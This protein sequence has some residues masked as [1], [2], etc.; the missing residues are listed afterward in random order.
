MFIQTTYSLRPLKTVLSEGQ[1]GARNNKVV[2]LDHTLRVELQFVIDRLID[3][4]HFCKAIIP[5]PVDHEAEDIRVGRPGEDSQDDSLSLKFRR[6]FLAEAI[7]Q[8]LRAADAGA[9]EQPVTALIE[10]D[11]SVR[12]PAGRRR[13]ARLGPLQNV[14]SDERA[15]A[16]L[17]GIKNVRRFGRGQL[18]HFFTTENYRAAAVRDVSELVRTNHHRVGVMNGAEALEDLVRRPG[19]RDLADRAGSFDRP[20]LPGEEEGSDVAAPR[21]V[22]VMI[23]R[24]PSLSHLGLKFDQAMNLVNRPFF[25]RAQD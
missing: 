21:R 19:L 17:F 1:A 13:H 16:P 11:D 8:F 22:A 12:K 4:V 20:S 15:V 5:H 7:T 10:R 14:P 2:S 3:A 6:Q 24:Q 18:L 9:D 23:K 25:R